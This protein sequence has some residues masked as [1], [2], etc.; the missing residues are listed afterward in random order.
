VVSV[1]KGVPSGTYPIV[2]ETACLYPVA[3][4]AGSFNYKNNIKK[5]RKN[6]DIIEIL[7]FKIQYI[8]K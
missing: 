6:E 7:E 2:H 3:P 1:S 5:S 4:Q 8:Q